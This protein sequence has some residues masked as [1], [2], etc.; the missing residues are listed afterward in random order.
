MD[1]PADPQPIVPCSPS[2]GVLLMETAANTPTEATI[3][4]ST[5]LGATLA[6]VRTLLDTSTLT[7]YHSSTKLLPRPKQGLNLPGG[8]LKPL[9][10]Q[11]LP[12]VILPVPVSYV[13]GN[14][15]ILVVAQQGMPTGLQGLDSI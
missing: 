4:L 10:Q 14:G 5:V 13:D 15:T 11:L 8:H 1:I 7:C 3:L 9:W 12:G 6:A 2:E